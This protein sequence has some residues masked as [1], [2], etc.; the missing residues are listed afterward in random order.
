MGSGLDIFQAATL[1]IAAAVGSPKLLT[2]YQAGLSSRL[3]GVAASSWAYA[4]GAFRL[5]EEPGLGVRVDEAVLGRFV[6][7]S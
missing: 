3:E 1:H 2:E 5:P 4:D 7:A 6:V